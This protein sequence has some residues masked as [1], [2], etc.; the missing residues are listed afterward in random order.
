M[1]GWVYLMAL[2]A[3]IAGVSYGAGPYVA[4][5]LDID[6][7]VNTTILCALAIVV[8]ATLILICPRCAVMELESRTSTHTRVAC[9]SRVLRM[10]P[11]QRNGRRSIDN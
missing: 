5:M 2:L 10:T 9:Q 7:S 8:V 6:P 11:S 1:T 4:V 3:T